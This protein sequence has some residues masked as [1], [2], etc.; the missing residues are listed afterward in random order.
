MHIINF[1]F[2]FYWFIFNDFTYFDSLKLL[3]SFPSFYVAFL[4]KPYHCRHS[5]SIFLTSFLNRAIS[6][7]CS[8][9]LLTSLD[10]YTNSWLAALIPYIL[11]QLNFEI[12]FFCPSA[13]FLSSLFVFF[14]PYK[15]YLRIL[16]YFYILVKLIV[17]AF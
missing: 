14:I 11:L 7:F 16:V 10:L 13:N 4:S 17:V 9:L 5:L 8:L 1:P 3:I 6:H 2:N 15:E 12:I